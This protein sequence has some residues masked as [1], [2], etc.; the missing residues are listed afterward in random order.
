MKRFHVHVNVADLATS[1]GYY[2]TLFGCAPNVVQPDYAKWMLDDPR[3][4]F[5]ISQRGRAPGVDHLGVQAD[6]VEELAAIGARLSAADAVTLVEQDTTCCYARS[7][8]FWSEDR[9]GCAG[10]VSAASAAP[11]AITHP[12]TCKVL[13]PAAARN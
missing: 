10:K 13:A 11:P 2:Q 6:G 12:S 4:N 9:R 7:D 5:A 1:I 3:V 8:K